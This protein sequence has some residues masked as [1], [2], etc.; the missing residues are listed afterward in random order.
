MATVKSNYPE[1][2][3][4]MDELRGAFNMHSR[5]RY[6]TLGDDLLD[7]LAQAIFDQTVNYQRDPDNTHFRPLAPSTLARK[8]R[9]GYP[10][11]IGVETG[12]MLSMPQLTGQRTITPRMASVVYGENESARQKAEWFQEGRKG[13]Q[14]ARRF[15]EINPLFEKDMETLIDEVLDLA[16]DRVA[17]G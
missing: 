5:G 15:F 14:P 10:D 2:A 8:R 16:V 12:E 7:V 1:I 3:R 13:K 6:R 4:G 9:L 11:T 17:M